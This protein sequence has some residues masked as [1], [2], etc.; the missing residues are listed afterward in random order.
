[1]LIGL[2]GYFNCLDSCG[3]EIWSGG[4]RYGRDAHL[5]RN[6]ASSPMAR[7]VL[8]DTRMPSQ[9][10]N[11]PLEKFFE[12]HLQAVA[13]RLER[14]TDEALKRQR[15]AWREALHRQAVLDEKEIENFREER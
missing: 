10:A 5:T 4:G 13:A 3:P 2:R 11:P 9:N 8:F 1:M 12:H 6:H 7:I 14:H 15:N